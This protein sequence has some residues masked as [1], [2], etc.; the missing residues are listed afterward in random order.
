MRSQQCGQ[1]RCGCSLLTVCVAAYLRL[2]LVHSSWDPSCWSQLST[3]FCSD[4][5]LLHSNCLCM[6]YR[7]INRPRCRQARLSCSPLGSLG[8]SPMGSFGRLFS[9][10]GGLRQPQ[11]LS[12]LCDFRVTAQLSRAQAQGPRA[13]SNCSSLVPFSLILYEVS[14]RARHSQSTCPMSNGIL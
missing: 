10:T 11:L 9:L 1:G 2:L 8:L 6:K 4:C 3:S 7:T 12:A 5:L 14:P 13:T